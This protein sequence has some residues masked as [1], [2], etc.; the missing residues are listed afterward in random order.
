LLSAIRAAWTA[1]A[2]AWRMHHS[3]ALGMFTDSRVV[4]VAE[5]LLEPLWAQ[6][7]HF[8][9]ATATTVKSDSLCQPRWPRRA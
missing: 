9:F 7:S 3:A 4:V 2:I 8:S 5:G 1:T 6:A